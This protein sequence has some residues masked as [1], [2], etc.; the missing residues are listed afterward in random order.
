MG[1]IIV[2]CVIEIFKDVPTIDAQGVN[3]GEIKDY[4]ADTWVYSFSGVEIQEYQAYLVQLEKAEFS[5][6]ID[7]DSGLHNIFYNAIFRKDNRV[8]S[9]FYIKD[10]KRGQVCASYQLLGGS[11]S[12]EETFR[13]VPV[14]NSFDDILGKAADY[15]AG[16]YVLT[17]NH[18]TK[19]DYQTYL[20]TLEKNGFVKF[21]DNGQ[22]LNNV[23][24]SS[25]YVKESLVVTVTYVERKK[26]T[27]ISACYD[28]PL[29]KHLFYDKSYVAHNREG[30]KTTL[31][32][33]KLQQFGNS[34]VIQLK[35]GHFIISD[36][37]MACEIDY[38]FDYLDKLTVGNEKPVIEAW[39][40]SHGH[41]D[42]SG[43]LR[44]IAKNP[45]MAERIYVEGLYYNEPN[46]SVIALDPP[47]RSDIA[48]M[49]VA[50]ECLRN[51]KCESP[52]IYRPQTGQRY[53]FNDIT[54]DIILGQEQL[55][56]EEYS[57]DFNDSSTWCMVTID[58]QK[59]LLGGDGDKGGMRFIVDTYDKEYM[60]VDFFT[61]L[62]HGHN[63]RDFFTDFCT[64][65]TVLVTAKG[66]LPAYRAQMNAHLKEVSK[67]WVTWEDGTKVFTL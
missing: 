51:T 52:K 9:V 27:F 40:I 1:E 60:T 42:H 66:E 54:I 31:H 50:A 6:V 65:R 19:E 25:I 21:V 44:K 37:G 3:I 32:M 43:V 59:C 17:V 48:L 39:F 16:N 49:R 20:F 5:K 64:V 4:D 28:L 29:S 57:G 62:H 10:Q 41:F 61:L 67:D 45:H 47:V 12:K 53:Y 63:T 56:F 22:G 34:F 36:G 15:G 23:V 26:K 58:G 24:F 38:L 11:K 14:M 2:N 33:L 18:T 46:D 8:V 35:N 7:N 55:P 13:D 30:A